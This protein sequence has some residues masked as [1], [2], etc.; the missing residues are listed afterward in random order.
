M[1]NSVVIN[2]HQDTHRLRLEKKRE[3]EKQNA[4]SSCRRY[5]QLVAASLSTHPLYCSSFL[6]LRILAKGDPT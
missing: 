1:K 5:S 4:I 3:K 2:N 6:S